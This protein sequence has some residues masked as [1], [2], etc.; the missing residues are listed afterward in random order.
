MSVSHVYRLVESGDLPALRV[1]TRAL[2]IDV[3]DLAD[4]VAAAG[5]AASRQVLSL[6]FAERALESRVLAGAMATTRFYV[7]AFRDDRAGLSRRHGDLQQMR[8]TDPQE[9][10]EHQ[11]RPRIPRAPRVAG[12]EPVVPALPRR[13]AHEPLEAVA[14]LHPLS[15]KA[16]ASGWVVSGAALGVAGRSLRQR[17]RKAEAWKHAAVGEPCNGG[18]SVALEGQDEQREG[19]RDGGVGG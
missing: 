3:A 19:T 1:G 17:G 13:R 11:K 7:Q 18:D 12:E 14:L 8:F 4:Y 9:R 10:D 5:D 6:G 2:R 15:L 16:V